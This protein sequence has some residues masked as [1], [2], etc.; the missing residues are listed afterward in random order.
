MST[1]ESNH[2]RLPIIDALRGFALVSIIL[3]HNI[4]HFDFYF[5]P[6]ELPEW[7]KSVDKNVWTSMF[8]LF[9]G[10]LYAIF[11]LLFGF[12]F[13]IQ[14]NNHKTIGSNFNIR[15]IWRMIV[16]FALGMI[17][18][19]FYEGDILSYF[20]L[21]GLSLLLVYQ[22]NNTAILITA[23]ILLL[24]PVSWIHIVHLLN[25]PDQPVAEKI[26][27]SYFI[28]LHT[29]LSNPSFYQL[30]KGNVINGRLGVAYWTWENG[31]F[32]QAPALFMLGML[33]GRIGLFKTSEWNR[34]FWKRVLI[35]SSILF[36]P[37]FYLSI[38]LKETVH[39][40]NLLLD[41]TLILSSL[42]NIAFT[43]ILI[44]S[45]ILLYQQAVVEHILSYLIPLGRMSLTNYFI[46]S[47]LGSFIYYGYGLA[48]Y[49]HT[50]ASYSLLIGITLVYFQLIFST[51]WLKNH[52][53]GPL[54]KLWHKATWVGSDG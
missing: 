10:K 24:Q 22:L 34:I 52:L 20:G 8:F 7:L 47:I 9:G 44:A 31:R 28:K 53:Q 54:E 43:A 40:Q 42:S 11:S 17:N 21:L 36:L 38:S 50:G 2:Q 25:H 12:T 45:F 16:L 51:W 23:I 27:H 3:L 49:K 5:F 18:S 19:M 32:F 39:Q 1:L 37:L 15:F 33:A 35:I 46:Q 41:L 13:Y 48:L 6:E 14:L 26:S 30:V 4:E 29:Y